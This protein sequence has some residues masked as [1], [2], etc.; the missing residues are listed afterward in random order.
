MVLGLSLARSWWPLIF[1]QWICNRKWGLAARRSKANWVQVGGM[2]SLLSFG[3]RPLV[4]RADAFQRPTPTPDNQW[5]R[6]FINRERGLHAETA[7]SSLTFMWDW[8][9]MIGLI[10]IILVV[11]G[12]VN[13]PDCISFHFFEAKDKKTSILIPKNQG[14]HL[15]RNLGPSITIQDQLPHQLVLWE[16]KNNICKS[17]K[18]EKAAIKNHS[19]QGSLKMDNWICISKVDSEQR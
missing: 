10:S 16:E 11:L 6:A 4:G 19:F 12:P 18:T 1:A 8:S 13:L 14:R 9:A 17:S 3:C 15:Q 7:Q 5:T 2:E